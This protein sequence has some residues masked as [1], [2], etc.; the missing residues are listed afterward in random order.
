MREHFCV[1][2]QVAEARPLPIRVLDGLG[3]FGIAGE[4][5]RRAER[6]AA[7]LDGCE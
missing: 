5:A 7:K 2:V 1:C 6:V 3:R 4:F